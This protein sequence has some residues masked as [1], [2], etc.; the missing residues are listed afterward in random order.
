MPAEIT[1]KAKHHL[2]NTLASMVSGAHLL[3]FRKAVAY[4]RLQGCFA[5]A[6]VVGTGLV[7]FAVTADRA[8]GRSKHACEI[9]DSHFC[10]R[11]HMGCGVVSVVLAIAKKEA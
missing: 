7:T 3:P 9:D 5:E 4:T 1:A 11:S 8:K 6:T 2:L 10:S